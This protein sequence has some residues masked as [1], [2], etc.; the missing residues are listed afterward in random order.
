MAAEA[1][2]A[3]A[4]ASVRWHTLLSLAVPSRCPLQGTPEPAAYLMVRGKAMADKVRVD[5]CFCSLAG[6]L[7]V[8][9][10]SKLLAARCTC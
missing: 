9:L 4:H 8:R 7:E 10:A 5:T 1:A 3:A 2:A 6:G